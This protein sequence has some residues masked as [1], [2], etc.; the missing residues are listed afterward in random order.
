MAC[1]SALTSANTVRVVTQA[2]THKEVRRGE[3]RDRRQQDL[4]VRGMSPRTQPASLAA[5]KGLAQHDRQRPDTLS[6]QQ[7]EG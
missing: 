3:V 5:G 1:K 2:A 7:V 6:A 4:V